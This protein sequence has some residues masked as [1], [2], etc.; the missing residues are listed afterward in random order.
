MTVPEKSIPQI[1]PDAERQVAAAQAREEALLR[2]TIGL[3]KTHP[4]QLEKVRSEIKLACQSPKF[5]YSACWSFPRGTIERPDGTR[6]KPVVSG[7]SIVLAREIERCMGNMRTQ[8]S[9]L[10]DDDRSRHIKVETWDLEKNVSVSA[11]DEFSKLVYRRDR[12]WVTADERQLREET[13]RRAAILARNTI[14]ALVPQGLIEEAIE[15]CNETLFRHLGGNLEEARRNVLES[16]RLLQIPE[17][18]L[19]AYLG[20]PF[21]EARSNDLVCLIQIAKSIQDRQAKWSEYLLS[22][23]RR[24]RSQRPESPPPSQPKKTEPAPQERAPKPDPDRGIQE[25]NPFHLEVE[26][27]QKEERARIVAVL[28]RHVTAPGAAKEL[29]GDFIR[30]AVERFNEMAPTNR[31]ELEDF[32]KFIE[33]SGAYFVEK[34]CEAAQVKRQG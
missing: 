32:L 13:N 3:A 9:I 10:R 20:R 19:S 12:G 2:F 33:N 11:E 30:Y 28:E 17:E 18:D 29:R 16:F 14:V 8:L 1:I 34:F 25:E 26:D 24:K 15:A 7:P 4:R 5:A 27:L 21:R 31:W 23:G 22:R 6:C